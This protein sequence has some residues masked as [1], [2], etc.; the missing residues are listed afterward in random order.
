MQKVCRL[1]LQTEQHDV[2]PLFCDDVN[3]DECLQLR[4]QIADLCSIVVSNSLES[5]MKRR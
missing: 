4:L 3:N 2:T 1:C 5:K